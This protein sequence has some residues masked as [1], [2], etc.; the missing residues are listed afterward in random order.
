MLIRTITGAILVALAVPLLIF[1]HTLAFPI[2]LAVLGVVALFE[3]FRCTGVLKNIFLTAPFYLFA[4][5]MPYFVYASDGVE[6]FA[7]GALFGA[8]LL[9]LISFAAS[10]FSKGAL[11]LDRMAISAFAGLYICLAFSALQGV[12]NFD[13]GLWVWLIMFA[14]TIFTDIFAYLFGRAFGKHK[15]IEDVSPKKTV[16]GSIG[17]S[18]MCM[19][20]TVGL[21]V[22]FAHVVPDVV[23]HPVRLVFLGLVVALVSQLGDLLMSLI[24]R[25]FGIKDYGKIFPG[26]GGVLDRFDSLLAVGMAVYIFQS[27]F[28]V[29]ELAS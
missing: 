27:F 7:P 19:L 18:I 17:G 29:L 3:L 2:A 15:L 10:V 13:C 11:P 25:H 8:F 20:M 9:L 6:S 5:V 16:E 4:I 24:K 21:G 22:L 23:M 28:P 14:G 1:S 12:R 26:H